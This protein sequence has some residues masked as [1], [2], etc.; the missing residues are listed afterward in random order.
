MR[1]IGTHTLLGGVLLL[2][3]SFASCSSPK[4]ETAA[5]GIDVE[6]S[7]ENL[8]E[9]KVSQLGKSIRF[10]PLET[11]DESLIGN[12]YT[13]RIYKNDLYVSTNGQCLLF[14]KQTGKFIREIG[15][16]GQGPKEYDH[17]LCYIHPTT[18]ELYFKKQPDKLVK[19]NREGEYLG[20]G[21]LPM[22]MTNQFGY[23]TFS[24]T[25]F[26]SHFGES[27]TSV[28]SNMLIYSNMY[29]EVKDTLSQFTRIGG[30]REMN[31][32]EVINIF[33]LFRQN[34]DDVGLIYVG[35]KGGKEMA[36]PGNMPTIWTCNGEIHYKEFF[37][38]TIRHIQGLEST[39]YLF[40]NTG[41]YHLPFDERY[42]KEGTR[43]CLVVL[44]V[45]ETADCLFFTAIQGI[46]DEEKTTYYGIY[47][48]QT[49]MTTMNQSDAG[50]TDDLTGFVPF[51]PSTCSAEGEYATLVE[52]GTIEEWLE[53]HPDFAK[54]GK[55][56]FL[57]D[58]KFDDNPVCVIVEP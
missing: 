39:P 45:H 48:K 37:C 43:G 8:T 41:K 28:G 13:V 53:E 9:L 50:L 4:S 42:E 36:I 11:T 46:H 1:K 18:G 32:V 6:G 25:L 51:Y 20:D 12:N 19:Y 17:S 24:D 56:A 26:L 14:D 2:L 15:S 54:E 47:D 23:F 29:G 34:K 22:G 33:K 58:M 3:A 5:N 7:F 30:K 49:G 38:D 57:N 31:Q 27:F 21:K 35:F 16:S 55:F 10:I 40:F 44:S 52:I